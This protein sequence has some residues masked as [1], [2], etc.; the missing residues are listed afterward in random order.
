MSYS[1]QTFSVGQVLQASHMN[2]VE[3]NI[4]DHVHGSASVSGDVPNT[5]ATQAQ[6]ETGTSLV[7]I[8]T[9]GRQKF[10]PSAIKAAGRASVIG[11]TGEAYNATV[12]DTGT[13]IVTWNWVVAF[14][15]V[16]YSVVP[17]F[18]AT[19]FNGSARVSAQSAGATEV[20]V[21]D[22]AGVLTDPIV[23]FITAA[24]DQ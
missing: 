15:G 21:T 24:G 13:G 17:G 14:S 4:R 5:A 3:V 6:Q 11:T 7:T 1:F 8:V 18:H 23:H 10:H 12:T 19:A 20:S 22:Y 16:T 9:P 2:Q